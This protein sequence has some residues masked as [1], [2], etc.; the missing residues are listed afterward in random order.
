[1]GNRGGNTHRLSNKPAEKG[2]ERQS[3]SKST[4][5]ENEMARSSRN[6]PEEGNQPRSSKPLRVSQAGALIAEELVKKVDDAPQEEINQYLG[7]YKEFFF[8]A[9]KK[10]KRHQQEIEEV[11][12]IMLG[13]DRLEY[14]PPNKLRARLEDLRADL[15]RWLMTLSSI[16]GTA[17]HREVDESDKQNRL[18][19]VK[20]VRRRFVLAVQ[21]LNAIWLTL[22][23]YSGFLLK[24]AEKRKWIG[25]TVLHI[26][27]TINN[28]SDPESE[29]HTEAFRHIRRLDMELCK[30]ELPHS[31][32]FVLIPMITLERG[33]I[34]EMFWVVDD[35]LYI[36][37]QC[38]ITECHRLCSLIREAGVDEVVNRRNQKILTELGPDRLMLYDGI[39]LDMV[40]HA[41]KLM[42]IICD[43]IKA[44]VGMS[45]IKDRLHQLRR[46]I[47]QT[48]EMFYAA[49]KNMVDRKSL[50]APTAVDRQIDE[51]LEARKKEM[52]KQ[53]RILESIWNEFSNDPRV[54]KYDDEIF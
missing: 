44:R 46:D 14:D 4:G 15:A 34:R 37:S 38:R 49:D 43:Y 48:A 32:T 29:W 6:P 22:C 18:R 39:M 2:D 19:I 42:T 1:M 24:I 26:L 28:V 16:D 7:I 5:K 8:R 13:S 36:A 10:M 52:R 3:T 40:K 53:A 35:H 45:N 41:T 25:S 31:N 47:H 30:G 9:T 17:Q 20:S 23:I 27:D 50:D 54:V 51:K 21:R 33:I 11:N 12:Q